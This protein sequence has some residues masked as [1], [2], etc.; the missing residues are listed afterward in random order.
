ML[1]AEDA[2]TLISLI[3]AQSTAFSQTPLSDVMTF[4]ADGVLFAVSG[5][6]AAA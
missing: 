5:E 6:R 3:R 4:A 1:F 2:G